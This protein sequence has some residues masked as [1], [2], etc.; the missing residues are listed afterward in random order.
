MREVRKIDSGK[1]RALCI[2]KDY[3]T[4]GD[5]DE[6]SNL[7]KVLCKKEYSIEVIEE[8]ARDIVI[9]SAY[10]KLLSEYSVGYEELIAVVMFELINE[11][12]VSFVVMA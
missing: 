1:V 4:R 9:H 8:I 5:N 2:N 6:Y 3:Y 10:E 11:C 7:L 12:C